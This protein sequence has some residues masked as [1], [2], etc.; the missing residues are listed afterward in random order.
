MMG[1]AARAAGAS[2]GAFQHLAAASCLVALARRGVATK[3][4]ARIALFAS[5]LWGGVPVLHLGREYAP[6]RVWRITVVE[7]N[8]RRIT[9]YGPERAWIRHHQASGFSSAP[10]R[11]KT[12]VGEETCSC[13]PLLR[14]VSE[15][16]VPGGGMGGG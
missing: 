15:R 11:L 2:Q 10:M 16:R 14:L 5:R 1:A 3:G 12:P 4:V 6:Q 9:R 8:K 13:R 7:R